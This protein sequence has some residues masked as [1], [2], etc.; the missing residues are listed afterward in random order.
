FG[1]VSMNMRNLLRKMGKKSFRPGNAAAM[2]M[3]NATNPETIKL[4][5]S[6]MVGIGF[7]AQRI[8]NDLLRGLA[9]KQTAAP[10]STLGHAPIKQ[11]V[12]HFINKKLPGGLP[13]KTARTLHDIEDTADVPIHRNPTTTS[14]HTA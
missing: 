10:A 9:N 7:K 1:D 11:Q 6:A 13:K 8:A 4:A 2:L 12:I 14:A 3:L 5:R